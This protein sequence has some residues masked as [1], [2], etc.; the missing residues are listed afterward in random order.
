MCSP[1]GLPKEDQEGLP[2]A[3]SLQLKKSKWVCYG[4]KW[5]I[6]HKMAKKIKSMPSF[7]ALKNAF[8]FHHSFL[9]F[10]IEVLFWT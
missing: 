2:V 4:S 10:I 1:K 3:S 9:I 7:T 8:H 5:A 6:E